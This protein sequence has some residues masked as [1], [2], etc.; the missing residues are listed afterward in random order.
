MRSEC[1]IPTEATV[2]VIQEETALVRVVMGP[3]GEAAG[4]EWQC[5]VAVDR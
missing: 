2:S 5:S 4:S 3:C 1:E